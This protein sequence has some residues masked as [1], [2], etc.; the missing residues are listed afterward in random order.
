MSVS[1]EELEKAKN[2]LKVAIQLHSESIKLNPHYIELHKTLRD[3][4][5]QRFEFCIE[6]A[7]KVSMK[8]LGLQTKAPNPAIREMAQNNLIKSPELW[9]EFLLARNKTSHSYD[10]DIAKAVYIEVEKLV[11]EL[12]LLLS[13]LKKIK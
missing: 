8:C 1:V 7:W 2:S 6:L 4:C 3:G 13:E 12:E 5:I 10:D 11:P 9:F